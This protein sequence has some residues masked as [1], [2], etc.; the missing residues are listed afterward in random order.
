MSRPDKREKQ[1]A[2]MLKS[3]QYKMLFS[4]IGMIQANYKLTTRLPLGLAR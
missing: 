2:V 1:N 4:F 3:L